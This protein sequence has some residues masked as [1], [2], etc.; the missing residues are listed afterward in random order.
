MVK[1]DSRHKGIPH[2]SQSFSNVSS[3]LGQI[4]LLSLMPGPWRSQPRTEPPELCVG[5]SAFYGR[6]RNFKR[7]DKF[8]GLE[9]VW[10]SARAPAG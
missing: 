8:K 7:V 2:R 4:S 3:E 6:S 5:L 1:L 10:S 9:S